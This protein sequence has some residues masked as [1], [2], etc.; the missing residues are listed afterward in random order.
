M[1]LRDSS[2]VSVEHVKISGVQGAD[3]ASIRSALRSAAESMSTLDV[4]VGR[5]RTAV[6][7]F[8][9]VKDLEVA[10]QFP[11][12]MSIRVIVRRPVGLIQ[13]PGRD[14]AVAADRTLLRGASLA[15]Q[16][17]VI[18]ASVPPVGRRLTD[19]S[20]AREVAVLAAAPA[21]LLSRIGQVTSV[22]GHGPVAQMRSGPSIYFGDAAQ[23]GRK[24]TAATEVLADPSSAGA[25]YIDVTD[26]EHPAAGATTTPAGG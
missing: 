23:L 22:A 9:E 21:G 7:P 1:W 4:Q 5:L 18:P 25:S 14:V 10:T 17:P 13:L 12:G 24:W 26:P 6:A 19:A 15:S 20:A 11:H 3:A 2:L 8:P 16:L